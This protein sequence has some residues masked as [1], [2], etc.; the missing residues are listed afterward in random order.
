MGPSLTERL[1]RTRQAASVAAGGEAQ[2]CLIV[3]LLQLGP[4]VPAR[5]GVESFGQLLEE[6]D[7]HR[8]S[9]LVE[10]VPAAILSKGHTR[11]EKCP[12]R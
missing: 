6:L 5:G 10:V 1:V 12:G 3:A 7:M 11:H 8:D 2:L 4:R 9:E